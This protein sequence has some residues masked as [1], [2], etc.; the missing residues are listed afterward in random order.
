M[1]NSLS[2]MFNH[3]LMSGVLHGVSLRNVGKNMPLAICRWCTPY[4]DWG[5]EDLSIFKL[6]LCL[7][8]CISGLTINFHKSCLCSSR[9]DILP[10]IGETLTINCITNYQHLV[11]YL[12]VLIS[13]RGPPRQDW[14]RLTHTIRDFLALWKLQYMSLGGQLTLVNS[15]LSIISNWTSVFELP[16]WVSL[17]IDKICKDF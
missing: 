6:I 8:E 14:L 11:T 13:S 9:F 1:A 16:K 10:S 12:S 7:F 4:H 3:A 17:E 2:S 15:M 5:L